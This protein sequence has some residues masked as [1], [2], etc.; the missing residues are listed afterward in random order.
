METFCTLDSIVWEDRLGFVYK[1][2]YS[3]LFVKSLCLHLQGLV[4]MKCTS[5]A[6]A[7]RVFEA[8]NA[9]YFDGNLEYLQRISNES[10]C[11]LIV[12]D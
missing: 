9:N 5:P 1:R 11:L 2:R 7:G 10:L 12:C 8:I 4:Y 3:P 6:V